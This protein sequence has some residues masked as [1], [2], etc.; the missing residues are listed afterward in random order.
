MEVAA[1]EG[2]GEEA[3]GIIAAQAG[4]DGEHGEARSPG[5]P[6]GEGVF[7]C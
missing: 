3:G 2:G 5:E 1:E 7:E 6:S 4:A